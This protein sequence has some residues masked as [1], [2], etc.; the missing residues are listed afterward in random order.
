MAERQ[1][2]LRV[3]WGLLRELLCLPA[4]ARIVDISREV[5]FSTDEIGLKVVSDAFP[6][7]EPGCPFPQVGARFR[8]AARPDGTRGPVFDGWEGLPDG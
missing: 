6:V 7:T 8:T 4:D 3:S 2:I 1:A 5:F